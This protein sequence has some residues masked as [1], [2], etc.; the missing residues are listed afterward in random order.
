MG[1]FH[2]A[3]AFKIACRPV[4]FSRGPGV[5]TSWQG[6]S[7]GVALEVEGGQEVEMSF[8]TSKSKGPASLRPGPCPLYLLPS[9]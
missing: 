7:L 2:K 8:H 1:T 5:A 3:S 6:D 9:A 4:G